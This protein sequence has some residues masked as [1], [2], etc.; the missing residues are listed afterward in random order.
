MAG[1]LPQAEH[2]VLQGS[3]CNRLQSLIFLEVPWILDD[4]SDTSLPVDVDV[5]ILEFTPVGQISTQVPLVAFRVNYFFGIRLALSKVLVS[6]L[7]RFNQT[8]S[9]NDL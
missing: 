4:L 8:L 7:L 2:G 6:T 1:C 3:L 5:H 9:K